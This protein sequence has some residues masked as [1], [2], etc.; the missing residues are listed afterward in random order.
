METRSAVKFSVVVPLYNEEGSVDRLH[1]RLTHVMREFGQAYE[2]IFVDDGSS[3][4]TAE[5]VEGLAGIDPS[6]RVITLGRNFGQTAALKAGFDA[7][8]GEIIISMDGDLQHDPAEI[9]RFI[10]KLDEGFDIVS[11]WREKRNDTWLTRRLPSRI[12]NWTMAQISGVPLHDF[13]TTFKAYRRETIQ[14]I[15]LYGELHRFIPALAAWSGARIVEIPI[16]NPPRQYGKSNYGISRTF[17]VFL[18]LLSTKFLLDYSTKP[19]H[20][21]GLFGLLAT[22]LGGFSGILLLLQKLILHQQIF[23]SN[24]ALAIA[25]AVLFVA[26]VQILCL[27][28]ASEMLCR[29]YYESQQKPIYAIKSREARQRTKIQPAIAQPMPAHFQDQ[30][31]SVEA[32][33][34]S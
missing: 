25:A 12:A 30:R 4:Q 8:C 22:G 14:N 7:A 33:A 3:D 32:P 11:G 9:P 23:A 13:G 18:D 6:L 5:I 26:G 29:T 28:L 27:G 21:F 19:L 17:R 20:F 31:S 16:T 15:P 1:Y 2:L 24:I 10:E 34:V